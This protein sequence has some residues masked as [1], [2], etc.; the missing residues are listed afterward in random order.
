MLALDHNT[1]E[2]AWYNQVKPHD[3][4]DLDFQAPPIIADLEIEGEER[5]VVI[6]SG[7]LGRVIAFDRR[8]G[9]ILWDTPVG[10]HQNDELQEIPLGET[11]EVLPGFLGGVETPMAFADGVVY[12]PLLNWPAIHSPTGYDAENA[13]EAA[14]NVGAKHFER[15]F[16]GMVQATGQLV[17]I[18]ARTGEILWQHDFD[19][20][21]FGGATVVN[22]LVFTST[23]DLTKG[24]SMIYA[25]DRETG[26]EVWTYQTQAGIIAW[27]AVA[28]DTII[29]A[30]GSG[31]PPLLIAFRLG[32]SEEL[33]TSEASP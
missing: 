5:P 14:A 3:L 2:L 4:F 31:T 11:V 20:P 1:G 29:F 19:S 8:N 16:A 30:A 27:P 18:D 25:L 32:A 7:K 12:V 26:E 17:A 24:H 21:N 15:L 23:F 10:D 13:A 33:P 6:G 28:G 22:D 9:D